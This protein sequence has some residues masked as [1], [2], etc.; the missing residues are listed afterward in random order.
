MTFDE[1][2]VYW[3]IYIIIHTNRNKRSNHSIAGNLCHSFLL[4]QK[5]SFNTSSNFLYIKTVSKQMF[6]Y[7][8][9]LY[10]HF[11]PFFAICVCIFHK[12]EVLMVILR[13]WT[14]GTKVMRK[15]QKRKQCKISKRLFLYKIARKKEMDMFAF[16]VITF[17]PI[18]GKTY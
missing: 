13:C 8:W 14:I 4:I 1:F 17:K 3:I 2:Y 15:T 9:P 12:T 7:K 11:W 18:I 16:C 10:D 6:L 5:I